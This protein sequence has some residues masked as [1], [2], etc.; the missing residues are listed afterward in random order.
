MVWQGATPEGYDYPK[1][2]DWHFDIPNNHFQY[3]LTWF[4]FASDYAGD[5]NLLSISPH[6]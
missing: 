2:Y 4:S 5:G 6:K 1:A 3:M